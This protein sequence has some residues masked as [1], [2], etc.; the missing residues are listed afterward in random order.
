MRMDLEPS[1]AVRV[2]L[3]IH[4]KHLD[5]TPSDVLLREL[6]ARIR[7]QV[8]HGKR[9]PEVFM[10]RAPWRRRG[11]SGPCGTRRRSCRRWAL[12]RS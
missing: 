12:L 2:F 6:A 8:W 4:R 9:L 5:E 11:T 10:T 3:N 7:D 1:L